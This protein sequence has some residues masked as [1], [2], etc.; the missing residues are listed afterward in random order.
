METLIAGN[1]V[2]P[3]LALDDK[4]APVS[5]VVPCYRCVDTIGPAV[6]SVAAQRLPPAEV[7]LVDDCSGDGTLERLYQVAAEYP[8][9]WVR[10]F[11]LARNGGPSA[12]RNHGWEHAR[13]PYIAFLDADDTWHPE[14][15]AIQMHVLAGDPGIALLAHAMNV[16]AR[17]DPPPEVR[18]PIAVRVLPNRLPLM[19]SP[20]PTASMLL[21]RDLPFRFDERRRRAEDFMLWAQILLSGYRCARIEPVLASW[22]KPPFGAGGLS[23]DMEAM[24]AAAIDVR[25][26]LHEQGLIGGA[27]MRVAA[28]LGVARYARRRAITYAR[29]FSASTRSTGTR[30]THA[31]QAS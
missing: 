27:R 1:T 23:G 11:T 9:G 19:G 21:R 13:Q 22:H 18:R 5:V 17:T 16:Q 10:V 7:L 4:V 25:R 15:L 3:T 30:A 8:D 6:A 28:V 20:F 12:A 31:D 2:R 24:Y 29:R 26:T 14:K